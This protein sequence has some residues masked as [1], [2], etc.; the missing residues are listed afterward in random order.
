VF[1]KAQQLAVSLA[2]P[3]HLWSGSLPLM[4][5]GSL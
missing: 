3:P 1:S 5:S 4:I 2:G